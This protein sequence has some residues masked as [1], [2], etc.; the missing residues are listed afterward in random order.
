[1]PVEERQ[2]SQTSS[3]L[4]SSLEYHQ[5]VK[6]VPPRTDPK[7]RVGRPSQPALRM[8]PTAIAAK[9]NEASACHDA[10]SHLAA[11]LVA[12][13]TVAD[14]LQD[15][16]EPAS[17]DDLASVLTRLADRRHLSQQTAALAGSQ[18]CLAMVPTHPPV[19]AVE[20]QTLLNTV[21]LLVT[22]LYQARSTE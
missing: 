14:V 1:M 12:R 18:R 13:S 20:V 19:T 21:A 9:L 11:V 5:P 2:R 17:S 4:L 16:G 6:V 22:E 15:F 8:M 7:H 3:A 10:G